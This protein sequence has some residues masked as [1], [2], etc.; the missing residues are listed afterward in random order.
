MNEL[1]RPRRTL[2]SPRKGSR[3]RREPAPARGFLVVATAVMGLALAAGVAVGPRVGDELQRLA[4]SSPFLVR[5]V[6]VVGAKRLSPAT[7]ADVAGIPGGSPLLDVDVEA[8]A[9]RVSALPEV[10]SARALRLPPDRVVVGVTERVAHGVAAAGPGGRPHLVCEEGVAFAPAQARDA[11]DLPRLTAPGRHRL[12]EP[13]PLLAQ[14]AHVA[15][16]AAA[17]GFAVAGVA[18]D[19]ADADLRLKG[20]SARVRLGPAPHDQALARLVQLVA[21]RPDLVDGATTIDVRFADRAVLRSD[22]A[23]KGAQQEAATRGSAPT[24]GEPAAG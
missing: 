12:G 14:A 9:A 19:D 7:I 3:P 4:R 10:A 24:S 15:A 13:D 16:K 6:A 8:V 5:S 1:G 17:A 23:P 18:V 20:L 21:R 22:D 11:V 2:R